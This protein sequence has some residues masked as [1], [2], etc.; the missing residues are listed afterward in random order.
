MAAREPTLGELADDLREIRDDLRALPDRLDA[1][2]VRR[3]VYELRI[4]HLEERQ[5]ATDARLTWIGRTAITG[6]LLP[7]VVAVV[8]IVVRAIGVPA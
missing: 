4:A 2:Y 1:T 5:E 8:L 3:D 7:I 6:V